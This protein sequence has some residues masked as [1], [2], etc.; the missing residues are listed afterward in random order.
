MLLVLYCKCHALE[1]LREVSVK[2]AVPKV[3]C[4]AYEVVIPKYIFQKE[5][6]LMKAAE[7]FLIRASPLSSP[8]NASTNLGLHEPLNA[9][10]V[11]CSKT[12]GLRIRI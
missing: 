3:K 9:K 4:Y 7:K 5:R 2:L 11:G 6:N 8:C 1:V 12:G 10:Q